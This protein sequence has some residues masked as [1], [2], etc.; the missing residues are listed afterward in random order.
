MS[1]KSAALAAPYE[2][3][4]VERFMRRVNKMTGTACWDWMRPAPIGYG[5]LYWNGTPIGTHRISYRIFRGQVGQMHV[6]HTCDR[7]A[8]VNPDHLFLG[9]NQDNIRDRV[10]KGRSR[11]GQ[12]HPRSVLK[13]ADVVE[14]RAMYLGGMST[15]KI[16]ERFGVDA[17][18]AGNAISGRSWSHVSGAVA[19]RP[20]SIRK[21]CEDDVRKIR[22]LFGTKSMASIGRDF[23]VS[24]GT[25]R[26]IRSGETWGHVS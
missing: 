15:S 14:A 5:Q 17:E 10:K 19:L 3:R 2:P 26:F 9:T 18:T 12:N 21:L 25:I 22:S 7:R 23:G 1:Q 13:R 24:P 16:G 11:R 8:C 4:D 20:P 6:C